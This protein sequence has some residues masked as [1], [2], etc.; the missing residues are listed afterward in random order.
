[1]RTKEYL[2]ENEVS[3]F[4]MLL[5]RYIVSF[6]KL[7]LNIFLMHQYKE[8]DSLMDVRFMDV[9]LCENEPRYVSVYLKPIIRIYNNDNFI[10]CFFW[11]IIFLKAITWIK[12]TKKFN[13][14]LKFKRFT[15]LNDINSGYSFNDSS[16]FIIPLSIYS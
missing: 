7:R 8:K 14:S 12:R 16:T 10:G 1:M 2:I 11:K 5:F 6:R 4:N 9:L 13:L 3:H 15:R